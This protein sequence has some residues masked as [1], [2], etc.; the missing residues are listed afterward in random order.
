MSIVAHP[1]H[2]PL[3]SPHIV[4]A[5]R[6]NNAIVIEFDNGE[7]ALYPESFLYSKIKECKQLNEED[8]AW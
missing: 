6:L 2:N 5:D 4:A 3:L 1:K 8:V 7:C